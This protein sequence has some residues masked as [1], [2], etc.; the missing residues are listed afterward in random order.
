MQTNDNTAPAFNE[1]RSAPG[2]IA[3]A[4]INALNVKLV[5]AQAESARLAALNTRTEAALRHVQGECGLLIGQIAARDALLAGPAK[6]Q[7]ATPAE[8]A[9]MVTVESALAALDYLDHSN[10]P[11]RKFE[12]HTMLVVAPVA[13]ERVAP[14][15]TATTDI[16]AMVNRF[17]AWPLPESLVVAEFSAIDRPIGT[18]LMNADEAKAMFEYVLTPPG[19]A[20]VATICNL[21]LTD[22]Q[23]RTVECMDSWARAEALPTYSQLLQEKK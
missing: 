1:R 14:Q 4:E 10:E 22:E 13:A 20:T 17:L 3:Q 19:D 12:A 8:Q 18:H 21:H 11:G 6:V 15:A 23:K 7:G 9:E 5:E 2:P 16:G